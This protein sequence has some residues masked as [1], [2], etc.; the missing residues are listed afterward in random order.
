MNIENSET[1]TLLIYS[2]TLLTNFIGPFALASEIS[3][4][5]TRAV[6]ANHP[7]GKGSL[8][9]IWILAF[10]MLRTLAE[11]VDFV[12]EAFDPVNALLEVSILKYAPS[13]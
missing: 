8:G 7:L 10:A 5:C 9:C 2:G 12:F 4:I 1:N 3:E 6:I 11:Q 13:L